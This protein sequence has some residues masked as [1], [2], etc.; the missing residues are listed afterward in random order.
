MP[1]A[2]LA[3]RRERHVDLVIVAFRSAK[4]DNLALLRKPPGDAKVDGIGLMRLAAESG[5]DRS[6]LNA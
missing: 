1:S 5:P 4:G 3:E 6:S 2:F